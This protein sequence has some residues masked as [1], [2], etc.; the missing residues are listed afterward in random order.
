MSSFVAHGLIG[1]VIGRRIVPTGLGIAV[2]AGFALLPDIDYA[3]L[4]LRGEDFGVR[5]THSLA[6]V[7]GAAGAMAWRPS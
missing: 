5:W 2:G 1:A 7:A 6:F 3:L 4:W